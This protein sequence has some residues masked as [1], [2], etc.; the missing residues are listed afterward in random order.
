MTRDA[1]GVPVGA[2]G[3]LFATSSLLFIIFW[4]ISGR[5]IA[6]FAIITSVILAGPE[7]VA[8]LNEFN[9]ILNFHD[10]VLVVHSV[11]HSVS[12]SV[13]RG[14]AYHLSKSV[15]EVG[16]RNIFEKKYQKYLFA[17]SMDA[18][19]TFDFDDDNLLKF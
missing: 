1:H 6:S 4:R 13:S 10:R 14:T 2:F 12:R 19:V 9:E 3:L 18:K 7:P 15:V 8:R 16:H 11:A 5:F 17:I